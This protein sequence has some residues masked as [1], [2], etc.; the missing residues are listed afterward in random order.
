MSAIRSL[1]PALLIAFLAALP[2]WAQTSPPVVPGNVPRVVRSNCDA[3]APQ[4]AGYS[5]GAAP[6]LVSV[7]ITAEGEMR[8]PTLFQSS[9]NS[10]RDKAALACADGYHIGYLSVGGRP[11]DVDWVLARNWAGGGSGFGPAIPAGAQ[12]K[13]CS[14]GYEPDQI[15]NGATTVS[16]RIATDGTVRDATVAESSGVPVFDSAAVRCVTSWRFYP[17]TQ[18]GRPVEAGQGLQ[19]NWGN[20]STA[21]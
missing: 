21:L 15:P 3:F 1:K 19:V 4:D 6:T 17:V 20:T 14:S 18:N 16:Y 7:R 9:G 12:N 8:N 5:R 13:A 11:A 2:A 10:E